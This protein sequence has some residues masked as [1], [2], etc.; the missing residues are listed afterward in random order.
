MTFHTFQDDQTTPTAPDTTVT[1][2]TLTVLASLMVLLPTFGLC[3]ITIYECCLKKYNNNINLE[4]EN[5]K[6]PSYSEIHEHIGLEHFE[7]PPNYTTT[8]SNTTN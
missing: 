7:I 8:T 3:A 5:D 6:L 1:G 2:I 4:D